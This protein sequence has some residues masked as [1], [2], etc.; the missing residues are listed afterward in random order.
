MRC[1]GCVGSS[2]SKMIAVLSPRV[3]E[4]AVQAVD[5]GIELAVG[6]PADVEVVGVEA[7]VLD[8][9]RR[10]ASSRG[11]A[12][13]G[14][15][16]RRGRRSPPGIRG[17][18]RGGACS[19]ARRMLRGRGNALAGWSWHP[20]RGRRC[21]E[22]AAMRARGGVRPWSQTRP[23]STKG[24]STPASAASAWSP[25]T[26]MVVRP[27]GGGT[28]HTPTTT[29]RRAPLAIALFV[30]LLAPGLAFAQTAKEQ[31]LEAR[32]AQLEAQVQALIGAQQQQQA[33]DRRHQ[34]AARPGQGRAG[35]ARRRQAAHPVHADHHRRPIRTAASATAASSR[36]TRW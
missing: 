9:R 23:S 14:P 24:E 30:A 35:R 26:A 4:V 13:S 15:R 36:S 17:R 20:S 3:G 22:C 29:G 34:G 19:N 25:C 32:I 2:G 11:A 10:R 12:R 16:T 18:S 5:A 31:E 1:A 6:V 28:M 7:D 8:P 27:L 33:S 21:S